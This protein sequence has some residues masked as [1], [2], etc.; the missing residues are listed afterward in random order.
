MG[1]SMS[2]VSNAQPHAGFHVDATKPDVES[3]K[4]SQEVELWEETYR[5]RFARR[6]I[7]PSFRLDSDINPWF[8]FDPLWGLV[9]KPVVHKLS[10][11]DV[12][13]YTKF[14]NRVGDCSPRYVKPTPEPVSAEL[15]ARTRQ[16]LVRSFDFQMEEYVRQ[17]VRHLWLAKWD[18]SSSIPVAVSYLNHG[19]DLPPGLFRKDFLGIDIL[20][21]ITAVYFEPG[22]M[23]C[24]GIHGWEDD[25]EYPRPWPFYGT[26]CAYIAKAMLAAW[27]EVHH[28]NGE[29]ANRQQYRWLANAVAL[30][31]QPGP[32]GAV[33]DAIRTHKIICKELQNAQNTPV[34]SEDPFTWVEHGFEMGPIYRTVII[35]L[36]KQEAF[37]HGRGED[38]AEL[39]DILFE[40][41]SVLLVCTGDEDNLSAPIDLSTLTA[42]GLTLPLARSEAALID[43]V[44]MQQVV[45]VRLRTAVRFVMDLEKREINASSRLTARKNILDADTLREAEGWADDAIAHAE[46]H[47]TIDRDPET[48]GAVRL[49]QASLDG[50][51]CGLEDEPIEY[52]IPPVRHW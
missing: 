21:K 24:F 9:R 40:R 12:E 32:R 19:D 15:K 13:R 3:T 39:C 18:G 35:I 10:P 5:E 41:C 27:R 50:D 6:V 22:F 38:E 51:R 48:W 29:L 1:L 2:K 46:S 16:E 30:E 8:T 44:G 49:A 26:G 14:R 20:S 25:E 47:G 42:A 28:Y 34:S 4:P 52:S 33:E 43:P 31:G 37:E 36:D 17:H 7:I 11:E 45:R 23:R